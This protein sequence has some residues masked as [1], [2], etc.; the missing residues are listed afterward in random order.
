MPVAGFHSMFHFIHGFAHATL[1][2]VVDAGGISD[3]QRRS[4][5][6]FG[7]CNGFQ[8]LLIVC[9]HGNLGHVNITVCHGDLSQVFLFHYFTC[10]GKLCH[11]SGLGSLGGLAAGIGI[12]FGVEYQDIDVFTAGNDVIQAAVTDII[13]PAVA[14]EHPHGGLHQHIFHVIQSGYIRFFTA[15]RVVIQSSFQFCNQ[16]LGSL[17]GSGAVIL[18]FQPCLGSFHQA[19]RSI[20]TAHNGGGQFHSL[21]AAMLNSHVHAV[22][23]F[24]VV[25]KQGVFP[26]RALAFLVH[27][28]R[29]RRS[30][31]APDGRTAGGVCHIHPVTEELGNQFGIWG[32]TTACTGAGELQQRSGELRTLDCVDGEGQFFLGNL[33]HCVQE[34][35][36]LF[37]LCFQGFHYQSLVLCRADVDARAATGA[38]I[39]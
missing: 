34:Y 9:T 37:G 27:C 5:I 17:A 21:V 7:F 30:R 24:G 6:C 23:E 12:N 22:A 36:V 18:S 35:I 29:Q 8:C 38:V 25:F 15:G 2:T 14:A 1:D 16:G 31:A 33:I 3:D 28:V 32:F 13:G 26:S 10:S 19:Y 11:L 4:G 39:R 20:F